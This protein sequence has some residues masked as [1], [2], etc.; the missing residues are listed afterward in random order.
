MAKLTLFFKDRKL[1]VFALDQRAAT[2]GRDQDCTIQ[3]DSLAVEPQHARLEPEPEG[4]RIVP[5]EPLT[6]ISVNHQPHDSWRLENGDRIQIGKHELVFDADTPAITADPAV[7]PLRKLATGWLQ[8]MSGSHLGRTIR[9]DRAMTRLGKSGT[10]NAVIARREDGY[11]LSHLEGATPPCINGQSIG[12]ISAPLKDGDRLDIGGLI[13]HFFLDA[14]GSAGAPQ[15]VPAGEKPQRRF[16]R[17]PFDAEVRLNSPQHSWDSELIDLS[18][19]GALIKRPQHWPETLDTELILD[20]K[21]DDATVISMDVSV[22]HVEGDRIGLQCQDIDLESITHLRRLVEL[23]LG[24]AG[25][26]ERELGQLG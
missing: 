3:I 26:L 7:T 8:I 22:A 2:I 11:Y 23:N 19:K 21:L 15:S 14:D 9:L 17:I 4:L 13:L 20:L 18:L 25:L 16:T 12:E 10:G 6:S 24:D 5:I 1:K